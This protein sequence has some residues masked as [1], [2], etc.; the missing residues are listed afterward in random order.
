MSIVDPV[1]F[2]FAV[3][4]AALLL[5]GGASAAEDDY[6]E[7]VPGPVTARILKVRDGDTAEVAAYVWPGQTVYVAVRLHGIDAP[8]HRGKCASEKAAAQAAQDR[9]AALV[10][11]ANNEVTLTA[12]TGDKYFG[13]VLADMRAG[14]RDVARTL[15]NEGHVAPYD[16][17]ARRSWCSP[18]ASAE[19]A[20]PRSPDAGPP[21]PPAP[22]A[23]PEPPRRG[24]VP[25]FPGYRG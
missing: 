21:A 23:R 18:D 19:A 12:I 17:K 24:G 6:L 1:R 10:A 7:T 22:S 13:R 3:L 15:L 14:D 2:S 4:A 9:F 8:E 5:A 16:G 11:A 20:P 25:G